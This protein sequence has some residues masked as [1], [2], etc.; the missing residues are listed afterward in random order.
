MLIVLCSGA[1]LSEGG[2][3]ARNSW[4]GYLID[5]TCARERKSEEKDLGEKHTRKCMEMPSCYGSGFGLL[6]RT[7]S[8][9]IFDEAGNQKVR[10]LLR[11]KTQNSG[12]WVLVHGTRSKDVLRVQQ[13]ELKR[14]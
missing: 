14:R 12:L 5:L 6:T 2:N 10:A 11:Q 1:G 13:I 9:L 3:A 8:L 7:N 4:T